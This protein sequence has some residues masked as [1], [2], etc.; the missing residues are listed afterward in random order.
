MGFGF[1]AR[2]GVTVSSQL[3]QASPSVPCPSLLL[4]CTRERME[5]LVE[6][7][8]ISACGG[9]RWRHGALRPLSWAEPGQNPINAR[10]L[11]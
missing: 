2:D 3:P 10:E 4:P 8:S 1:S 7:A 9:K 5:K 6:A 11:L